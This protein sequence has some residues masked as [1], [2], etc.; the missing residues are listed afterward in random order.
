[1][2]RAEK[3]EELRELLETGSDIYVYGVSGSGKTYLVKKTLESMENSCSL[4]I[5]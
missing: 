1:M 4:Y 2:I 3:I 5:N